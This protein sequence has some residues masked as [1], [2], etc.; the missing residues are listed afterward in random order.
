MKTESDDKAYKFW[1]ELSP[2]D[3]LEF[4]SKNH[5]WDGFSY[6]LYDYLPDN[7]Q[8]EICLKTA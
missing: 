2:E 3:R 6:Y 5:F 1:T 7:I 4:L 8:A